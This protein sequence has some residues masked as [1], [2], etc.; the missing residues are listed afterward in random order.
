M[1]KMEVQRVIP[2]LLDAPLLGFDI[3]GMITQLKQE[4]T[5]KKEERNAITLVKGPNLR[6]V[7]ILAH[8]FSSIPDYQVFNPIT[9]HVIEGRLRIQSHSDSLE[10]SKGQM[11]T[12]QPGVRHSIQ[13][14]EDTA[15]LLTLATGEVHPAV[16]FAY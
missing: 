14:V 3:K 15:F 9:V 8:A 1:Q 13:S 11:L 4:G 5:W 10:L 7:L 12:L 16:D 6:I 2:R